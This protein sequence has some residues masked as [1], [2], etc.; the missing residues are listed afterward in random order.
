MILKET[1]IHLILI[2]YKKCITK[3][4][5]MISSF[6]NIHLVIVKCFLVERR[7]QT[8][9]L[10]DLLALVM[11]IQNKG[12]SVG[13][14]HI[15]KEIK[16]GHE[17]T[18]NKYTHKT[19]APTKHYSSKSHITHKTRSN[20]AEIWS[21]QVTQITKHNRKESIQSHYTL[22]HSLQRR[23][24]DWTMSNIPIATKTIKITPTKYW[25]PK[26]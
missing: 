25:K 16:I 8:M 9:W 4:P 11:S 13:H 10:F 14:E 23:K 19:W 6:T 1:N 20:Q 12:T 5:V 24:L 15:I 18:G 2:G 7:K 3:R 21:L 26:P 22:H 17:H